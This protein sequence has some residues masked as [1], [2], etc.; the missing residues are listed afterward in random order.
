MFIYVNCLPAH[1][2]FHSHIHICAAQFACLCLSLCCRCCCYIF[3]S[4]YFLSTNET[5]T[6]YMTT[7]FRMDFIVVD[8]PPS[9]WNFHLYNYKILFVRYFIIHAYCSID[10]FAQ[11]YHWISNYRFVWNRS[12]FEL[13]HSLPSRFQQ[14]NKTSFILYLF[15]AIFFLKCT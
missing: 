11:H 12:N 14:T 1:S 6:T 3:S 5:T 2:Q 13:S 10:R 8:S 4:L 15:I 7:A 9:M